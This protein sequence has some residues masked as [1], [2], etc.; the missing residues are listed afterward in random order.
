[1]ILID[2]V[3]FSGKALDPVCDNSRAIAALN[4]VIA[5]DERVDRV[6]LPIRDGITLIR[7]R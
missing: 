2:N 3:L 7:K 4:E 5:K 1:M 6:M